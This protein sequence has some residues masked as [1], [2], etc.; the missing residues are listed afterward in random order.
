MLKKMLKWSSLLVV[1]S[2]VLSFMLNI[3]TSYASSKQSE[4]NSA[5]V[6]GEEQKM[7]TSTGMNLDSA[8]S[9]Q[10][11]ISASQPV[12]SQESESIDLATDRTTEQDEQATTSSSLP[13][14][15]TESEQVDKEEMAIKTPRYTGT[16]ILEYPDIVIPDV[17]TEIPGSFTVKF[18]KGVTTVETFGTGW[19]NQTS[20]GATGVGFIGKDQ[21]SQKGAIGLVYKNV[22]IY[23]GKVINLRITVED[24]DQFST[25]HN[26]AI[27][28]RTDSI[29]TVTQKFNWVDQTWAFEYEDGTPATLTNTFMTWYDIDQRQVI[30]FDKET[31]KK[32]TNVYASTGNWIQYSE[33]E[34]GTNFFESLDEKSNND[35]EWAMFTT[36]FSG[37]SEIGLRWGKDYVGVD[38]TTQLGVGEFLGFT[39]KK[40]ARTIPDTPSKLVTDRNEEGV[41]HNELDNMAESFSYEI[42][43]SVPDEYVSFYY[44]TFEITDKIDSNLLIN[45]KGIKVTDDTNADVTKNFV[46]TV[47]DNVV[48]AS[49]TASFLA[50]ANFYYNT[51]KVTIPVTIDAAKD[52]SDNKISGTQYQYL[53]QADLKIV[54]DSKE[55][56]KTSNQVVTDVYLHSLPY[57][58]KWEDFNNLNN[59]R[60]ESI[61]VELWQNDKK[62]DEQTIT[63]KDNWK[64]EFKNLDVKDA[65]GKLYEYTLKDN[66]EGYES[67][68]QAGV[69]TNAL[70]LN[71]NLE[72]N[73]SWVGDKPEQR[74]ESIKV[75]LYQNGEVYKE[76]IVKDDGDGDNNWH[77]QFDDI[78]IYD[79]QGNKYAYEVKEEPVDGY[80]TTIEGFNITNTF[81]GY[82]DISGEKI[83]DDNNNS[84]NTRPDTIT[85]NL[86]YKDEIIASKEVSAKDNWKFSFTGLP[87]YREGEKA[88]YKITEESVENYETVIDGTTI[89]NKLIHKS[90]LPDTG[91]NGTKLFKTAAAIVWFM[92][93]VSLFY[94]FFIRRKGGAQHES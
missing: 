38:E 74:P 45:E 58:K 75:T 94:R 46:I 32:L 14:A 76:L 3:S 87:A 26:G 79:E 50:K 91:G 41:T 15:T 61:T 24:W 60:P 57:E 53:N 34:Y 78:P 59:T 71:K 88:E 39:A 1:T 27:A 56:N 48:T 17:N 66:V 69:L 40:P 23:Q 12:V 37:V 20:S 77:Y 4:Q 6:L 16:S 63:E 33:D 89:T 49:A 7:E 28:Y 30:S 52:Q 86:T 85:V 10:Q 73:K 47:K 82:V 9:N 36:L 29:G 44:S 25:K 72:G 19:T 13:E 8:T 84:Y 90:V 43:Q 62:I 55:Y 2:M 54:S 92:M 70:P 31:S 35:D 11:E 83:W 93:L 68:Y 64:G 5:Q 67:S 42:Y 21:E 18:I 22:G 80:Q 51:Y 81:M 65:S